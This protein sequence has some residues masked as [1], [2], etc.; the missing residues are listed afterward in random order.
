[1]SCPCDRSGNLFF[2]SMGQHGSNYIRN[3]HHHLR[4][5]DVSKLLLAVADTVRMLTWSTGWVSTLAG[6]AGS[7][8]RDDELGVTPVR[9][10][11]NFPLTLA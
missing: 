7:R 6:V 11:W 10:S 2:V 5:K 8:G 4:P 9:C 3:P 1:M